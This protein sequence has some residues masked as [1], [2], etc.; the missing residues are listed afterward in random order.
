LVFLLSGPFMVRQPLKRPEK[1]HEQ[2]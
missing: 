1:S 2:L